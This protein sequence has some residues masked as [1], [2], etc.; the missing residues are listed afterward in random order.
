[1][2]YDDYEEPL[3]TD[4]TGRCGNCHKNLGEKDKYCRYCGTPRGEGKFEPFRNEVYCVYAPPMTTRH[5][6]KECGYSWTV[7]TLGKDNAK[8]CPKCGENLNT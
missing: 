4:Y 6:C 7:K 5:K 1:M 2:N 8:F 3:I